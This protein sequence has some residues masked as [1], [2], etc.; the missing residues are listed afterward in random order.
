MAA[1]LMPGDR[2]RISR[3]LEVVLATGRSL[4]ARHEEGMPVSLDASRAVK[5][6]L[7]PDR[8]AISIAICR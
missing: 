2:S 4:V 7:M 8:Q 5:I 6:F 1:R 3:A